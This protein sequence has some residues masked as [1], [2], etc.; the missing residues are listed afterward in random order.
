M[1]QIVDAHTGLPGSSGVDKPAWSI[2]TAG[3]WVARLIDRLLDW[4]ERVEQRHH[5]SGLDEH[6]LHDI[7]LSRSDVEAE[8]SKPFWKV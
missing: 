7:G 5:L 4:Q 1:V 3:R 8:V 2:R 6:L